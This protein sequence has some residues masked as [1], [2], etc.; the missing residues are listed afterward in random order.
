MQWKIQTKVKYVT[1]YNLLQWQMDSFILYLI[2]QSKLVGTY[3]ENTHPQFLRKNLWTFLRC[4]GWLG[5]WG[6]SGSIK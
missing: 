4:W 6:K 1:L 2:F 5:E 3:W